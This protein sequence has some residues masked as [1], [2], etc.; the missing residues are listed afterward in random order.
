[1]FNL[2]SLLSKECA[3]ESVGLVMA[4]ISISRSSVVIVSINR[5]WKELRA[6]VVLNRWRP[7][8]KKLAENV[9]HSGYIGLRVDQK[10]CNPWWFVP[11]KHSVKAPEILQFRRKGVFQS[12]A[13]TPSI[14]E[15]GCTN[16]YLLGCWDYFGIHIFWDLNFLNIPFSSQGHP[17]WKLEKLRHGGE[18][19]KPRPWS[20]V[21]KCC[22]RSRST[23][24]LGRLVGTVLISW[25]SHSE[26]ANRRGTL[27][28]FGWFLT[29]KID[30]WKLQTNPSLVVESL[31]SLRVERTTKTGKR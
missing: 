21:A 11:Q 1:M 2:S 10:A 17:P 6:R 14:C 18:R 19:R 15:E 30:P 22:G 20:F 25:R 7:G 23:R 29:F 4:S 8:H 26:K 24:L 16:P 28:D 3:I 9:V 12:L 27:D 5:I 13:S 31:S